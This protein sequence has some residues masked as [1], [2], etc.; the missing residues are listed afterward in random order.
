MKSI[1]LYKSKTGFTKE[2]AEWIASELEA[3]MFEVSDIGIE[4]LDGYDTIIFGGGLYASHINGVRFI[5]SNIDRL[6][7]KK[8][9]VFATGISPLSDDV[10]NDVRSTNFDSNTLN[11]IE[12]FYFRGGFDYEHLKRLDKFMMSLLKF[13]L[14]HKKHLNDHERGMLDAYDERVDFG[15]KEN[16]GELISCVKS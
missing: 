4:M 7:Q 16:I 12:F 8:V 10:L 1:V 6:S 14:K 15:S 2:Y 11:S 9:V 3:D 5:T 13:K